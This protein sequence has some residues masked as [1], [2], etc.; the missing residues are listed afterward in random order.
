MQLRMHPLCQWCEA[1]GV[2]TPASEVHHAEAHKGD[3]NKF[4]LSPLVSLCA[5]CHGADAQSIEVSGYSHRIGAD[6]FPTDPRHPFYGRGK[7]G[8]DP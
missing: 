2:L 1:R 3:V 4:I 5:I 7:G 6:G 8:P